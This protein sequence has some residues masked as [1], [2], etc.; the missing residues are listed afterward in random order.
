MQF[1]ASIY[2][3]MKR[4]FKKITRHFTATHALVHPARTWEEEFLV[5]KFRKRYTIYTEQQVRE[6]V[7]AVI[8]TAVAPSP[9]ELLLQDVLR[10]LQVQQA[11]AGSMSIQ[12][13][14]S[15]K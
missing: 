10:K 12:E 3:P 2:Q 8:R 7:Q 11:E 15:M 6:A 14:K 1:Y 9:G 4:L 13:V 5:Q